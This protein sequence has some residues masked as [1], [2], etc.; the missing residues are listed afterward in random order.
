MLTEAPSQSDATSIAISRA[1]A[2][3]VDVLWWQP[4]RSVT[5]SDTSQPILYLV[6]AGTTPPHTWGVLEDWV[7]LPADAGEIY[8][9][10]E[11]LLL[12]LDGARCAT[13]V[14][15]DGV[16]RAGDALVPLSPMEGNLMGALL[17]TPN[18]MVSRHDLEARLWPNGC[19]SDPRAI[20]NRIKV[21]RRSITGL[22][23]RIHTVRGRG[24][25]LELVPMVAAIINE[26][27]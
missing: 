22:P 2:R 20:D 9:R 12:R 7:R 16:L 3:G 1:S 11:R 18:A 14:D 25:M 23:M 26:L 5:S 6:E 15:D 17:E 13:E 24:F 21:L 27:G 10:V 4:N 8:D 19:P